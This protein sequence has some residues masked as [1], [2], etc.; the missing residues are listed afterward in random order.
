MN[1]PST[2]LRASTPHGFLLLLLALV[3]PAFVAQ[4]ANGQVILVTN[5]YTGTIGEY[6]ATT[7]ATYNTA[8]ISGA[9]GPQG[10]VASGNALYI[11]TTG[12]GRV[13]EYN[14]NTGAVIN[15]SFIVGSLGN[16]PVALGVYGAD[17]L[18]SSV[19]GGGVGEYNLTTGANLHTSATTGYNNG[20]SYG[21]YPEF[22]TVAN[23]VLYV[24]WEDI[25]SVAAFNLTSG[26][27]IFGINGLNHPYGVAV[28]GGNLY[29]ANNGNGL[30]GTGSVSEYNA[31]TGAAINASLIGGLYSPWGLAATGNNLFVVSYNNG[32]GGTGSIG[33]YNATTGAAI[34]AS[35]ITGLN[36][37]QGILI[38]T[39]PVDH[40]AVSAPST[41]A[42]GSSF[43]VTVTAQD[44]SNNTVP[45]YSGT[46][47]LT[48]TDGLATLPAN[49]TLTNGTKTFTVTLAATGN[50]TVTATDTVTN[51]ITGV[52]GTI[53][54]SASLP[55]SA[56][57]ITSSLSASGVFGAGFNY[58]ITA[59][60]SPTGYSASG[61]PA[62]LSVNTGTGAITGTPTAAGTFSVTIGASNGIGPGS[63]TLVITIPIDHFTVSAP[64]SAYAGTAISVTVTAKDASN[65]TATAYAGTV[66]LTSSDGAATLP[67]NSA[68]TNGTK[69]FTVTLATTGNQTVTATD[70]VTHAIT[71]TSGS[72]AVSPALPTIAP[73]ITSGLNVGAAFGAAFNYTIA[74]SNSPTGYSASGLPAGL[75]VNTTTGVI[76]GTPSAAGTFNVTIGASNGIG[77]GSATLVIT[78][79]PGV[80]APVISSSP[81]ASGQVGSA[82]SYTIL[83]S[84][85]PTGFTAAG[86]PP[87]LTLSATTGVISGTPT[88]PGT[89]S[90][91]LG[92]SD[93]AGTGPSYTLTLTVAAGTGA[94][95]ITSAAAVIGQVGV[96]FNY[97]IATATTATSFSATALP[98]GLA[99]NT[100]TGVISGTPTAVGTT[101]V[102]IT[103]SNASGTGAPL[104]LV[105]VIEPATSA[106]VITSSLTAS[107]TQGAAFSYTIGG[108]NTPTSFSAAGLPS[109]LAINTGTGLISGTA[110][111]V[112]S[113]SVVITATNASGS[114]SPEILAISV[115]PAAGAPAITSGNTAAGAIGA[116]F[117]YQIT[118][119]H[120]ATSYAISGSPSWLAI[121]TATGL[122]SGTPT[123]APGIDTVI[124]SATNAS[125]T[126]PSFA[127]AI[128]VTAAAGT[129]VVTST[130]LPAALTAGTATSDTAGGCLYQITV[131]PSANVSFFYVVGS[132][133]P[134][135]NLDPAL[136][137]IYGTPT[138][139][140]SYAISV[141]AAN[142]TGIG[143]PA[144]V[145]LT[146]NAA[147][148]SPTITN[149]GSS[150]STAQVHGLGAGGSYPSASGTVGT[151]FSYQI[152]ASGNPTAYTAAGLPPG[153]AVNPATGTINGVP[154]TVGVYTV[155]ISASNGIGIGASTDLI[156]TISPPA[157]APTV[158][159]SP[160]DN[161]IAGTG[162]SYQIV[163]SNSPAS[164]NATGLPAGLSLNSAAGVISGTPTVPGV[165]S[166]S[167]SANNASGA[168]PVLSLTLTVS[169]T[170]GAPTISSA[171]TTSG[172]VAAAFSTYQITASNGPLTAFSA[173]NLP[174]GLSLNLGTGA[175]TGTPTVAG[176]YIA[177]LTATN[178]VGQSYPFAL[179]L[180]I[181][182]A[183]TSSSVTSLST[184]SATTGSA[185]T[186]QITA[187]NSPISYNVAGLPSGLTVNSST[188]AI[189]GSIS[190][191]ASY[192]VTISVN[193]ATGTGS[194]F[195][196]TITATNPVTY[197]RLVNLSARAFV[198]N[199]GN[200]LIAGFGISGTGN[201]QLLLRGVGPDMNSYFGVPDDLNNASLALYDNGQQTGEA[202]IGA[203]VISS[204][205]GWQTNPVAGNSP[206]IPQVTVSGA[207]AGIMNT[208]GAFPY[209]A[210]S[211]DASLLVTV[212]P[213]S[214]TAQV[215]GL[216]AS[217]TGVAL[218]EIYDADPGS[219]AARLI[220][221]SARAQVGTGFNILIAGFAVQGNANENLLIR[222][223]GPGLTSYFGLPGTMTNPQLQLFDDG[224]QT[225]EG[226]TP[227]VIATVTNWGT[228]PTLGNS[229]VVVGVFPATA[230]EMATVGAFTLV[231]GSTDAAM[232]V[233]V[234]PRPLHCTARRGRRHDGYRA[235]RGL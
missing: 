126:S 170:T 167:L 52:S 105:I 212:P 175:I 158:S 57:V 224:Q 138:V 147:A 64:S 216:G 227:R 26:N 13:A 102:T 176:V 37:P 165:Y 10:I 38:T 111:V 134:G 159:S 190:V 99:L 122:L 34:N 69:T 2:R 55:T 110:T 180:T 104:S 196:L 65:V 8:F 202:G 234:P 96:S 48:S 169:P 75:S 152:T 114:S 92:A 141:G 195:T 220:N 77:P 118:A 95:A 191:A 185:F 25:N 136:G 106:P 20:T 184:A 179:Q 17:L 116:P 151:A 91:A 98:A 67:A 40:F 49:S 155:L 154:T 182:P 197:V 192:P 39:V 231:V 181:A 123:G 27:L 219:P 200:V 204:N 117:S 142:P 128:T 186:Y 130:A 235:G 168:G 71:G 213:S 61:L 145:T 209:L 139:P 85:S 211:L 50:Q 72:I 127:L 125:G 120:A 143:E 68:L 124:L 137:L 160:T 78:V 149:S 217:P 210:N 16:I 133:P 76:S 131:L 166:I 1:H 54:V 221:I 206:E 215:S 115:N 198:N 6:N 42:A 194:T 60:N 100:G 36:G 93:T 153:L 129:P 80:A 24:A 32:G 144:A 47:A 81:Q 45:T 7:G 56:P 178:G 83:A 5:N 22:M 214:F 58:S 183:V 225:G 12:N 84:N 30:T 161:A 201:K 112:G 94:P 29:I 33:E 21:S 103:A 174:A 11:T 205:N 113:S 233:T 18:A 226:G 172:T 188:G 171:S 119:S 89:Y 28:S 157:A 70:T 187:G 23:G 62:G 230:Q 135:L 31:A 97:A 208:L 229:P 109:G 156:I 164:Y 108:T 46:V 232:Y 3:A 66:A 35:F 107:G 162:Y 82:F 90:V 43:S 148:G 14:L 132:L 121:N 218:A 203:E 15:S 79:A 53:A 146:I 63:A 189:S 163:A 41:A 4:R 59:T 74:A 140:G 73:A 51:T 9:N 88:A 173:Q 207:S 87:G 44:A 228:T 177:T 223:V 86:L 101:P 150:N 19:S 199:G 222:G 193:N